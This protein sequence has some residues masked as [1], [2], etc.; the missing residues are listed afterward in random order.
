MSD[1]SG[2]RINGK[3]LVYAALTGPI[4]VNGVGQ[5]GP[6]LST[7]VSGT[8]VTKMTVDEPWVV[9]ELKDKIGKP[10]VVP[11]PLTSF[12]HTVLAK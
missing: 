10:I 12:T 9:V 5:F 2:S 7:Q 3:Q 8:S 4:F 6:T 1:E 11:I